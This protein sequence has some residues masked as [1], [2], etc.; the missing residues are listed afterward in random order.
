LSPIR[1]A[2]LSILALAALPLA[3]QDLTIVSKSTRNQDPPQVTTSYISSEKIRMANADGSE[4]LA[5]PASGKFTMID[6]KKK[7]YYVVTK[8]EMEAAAAAMAA[9]MKEME[10]QMKKAQEQM[11]SLPPEMQQKMAGLMSGLAATVTVTKGPG[12]RTI[13]GYKCENWTIAVGT[14]SKTEQ[15]LTTEVTYPPQ[16]WDAYRDFAGSMK[17]SLQAMGPMAQ[18]IQDMQE[19]T[20]DMKGLP[21]ATT[22]STNIMGKTNSDSQEVTEIKKGPIPASAWQIPAGYKQV[23]SPMSKMAKQA[24]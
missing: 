8:Q 22:N 1:V 11:K 14:L 17:T 23:E 21:L 7:E 19:K 12:T 20:K 6:N 13:A 18:G 24:K 10:P 9:R 5:E 4:L 15:C 3:A 16:V 2:P